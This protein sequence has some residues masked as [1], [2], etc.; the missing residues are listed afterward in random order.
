M[1]SILQ[2]FFIAVLVLVVQKKIFAQNTSQVVKLTVTSQGSSQ[3][4]AKNNALRNAIQQTIGVFISTNTTL[5]NDN[6][7][8]DEIISI[9]NGTIQKYL[10][11]N[12]GEL[13]N[14]IYFVTLTAEVSV[15]KLNSFIENK[16]VKSSFNGSLFSFNIK[17][18]ELATI[19]ETKAIQDLKLITD[20][21]LKQTFEYD[22]KVGE[23]KNDK[24]EWVVPIDFKS[25]LNLNFAT[26]YNLVINTMESLSLPLE[27]Q[28]S[29]MAL[30]LQSYGINI[31]GKVFYFRNLETL[32]AIVSDIFF[33]IPK[34]SFDFKLMNN[35]QN[36]SLSDQYYYDYFHIGPN[37]FKYYDKIPRADFYLLE[38]K[39][40]NY[41]EQKLSLIGE[42]RK[43]RIISFESTS[44][45]QLISF[46]HND[47]NG[48]DFYHTMED[49]CG[50]GAGR[51]GLN[52]FNIEQFFYSKE[53]PVF[54]KKDER[55]TIN[56]FISKYEK[57]LIKKIITASGNKI[58]DFRVEFS[59]TKL[60]LKFTNDELNK[61]DGFEIKKN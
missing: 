6:L 15:T 8:K 5:L 13:S 38:E 57:N 10:I 2:F 27:E 50:W 24:G 4:D 43:K 14:G 20:Q 29:F 31:N 47:R 21:L 30:G 42:N 41:N 51:R 37:I 48:E 40:K 44:S 60:L 49:C 35:V 33:E 58:N 17:Q 18:K 32:E 61:L 19:N 9:S 45:F 34:F 12:E 28:I 53:D 36:I 7:E 59:N 16:G 1:K 26:F 56:L 39:V 3:E 46:N 55:N 23:P 52:Y 11:L 54:G 22:L 25:Y